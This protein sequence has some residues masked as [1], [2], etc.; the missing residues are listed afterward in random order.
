MRT[1]LLIV[2][3][4]P[5][6]ML[7]GPK[8][9][10]E[11][12][13][14]YRTATDLVRQLCDPKFATREAAAQ[15][16]VDMGAAAVPAITAGT[17][18]ADEE[19]RTR[20]MALL[21]KAVAVGWKRR[22][23]AFL[24]DPAAH[25]DLPLR[26]EWEKLTGKPDPGSRKLYAQVLAAQGPLLEQAAADKKLGAV[27]LAAKAM[28]LPTVALAGQKQVES[29]AGDVA[30]L[31]LAQAYLKVP[32]PPNASGGQSVSSPPP[33]F[34]Q[35]TIHNVPATPGSRARSRNRRRTVE[36]YFIFFVQVRTRSGG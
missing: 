12:T 15:K 13:P 30:G 23:E 2:I 4:L 26:A 32:I 31:L 34:P 10:D 36:N 27:A 21:P 7:A 19:V 33:R 9:G 17:K 8:P 6:T 35:D 29:T 20:T 25:R 22:A 11:G 3:L 28:E 16:L 14:E 5:A 18:S 24:A 1:T